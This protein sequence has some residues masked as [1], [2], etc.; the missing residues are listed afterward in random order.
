MS[1]VL[2]PVSKA[3]SQFIPSALSV[4]KDCDREL[5]SI[6][7]GYFVFTLM[8]SLFCKLRCP[9]CY[10]SL[11]QRQDRTI[12][13]VADLQTTCEKVDAY[14]DQQ[15][16]AQ[17]TIVC[18]WYGG[19]P[20]SM[21]QDYFTNAAEAINGVF[22]PGQ[23]YRV[24]HT[25]LTSLV[26]V[27]DDWFALFD[28]Y[29]KG[30]VQSSYD[31][32]MRGEGYMK[33]WDQRARAAVASGLRLSTISVVNRELLNQGPEATLDYLA[34]IGVAETSWLPFMWNEQNASGAYADYAPSMHE[35][36]DF[37]VGL[38][39]HW[40]NQRRRG[41]A[42]PEIG[43]LRFILHQSESPLLA[44]IAGQ[45]LFLLPNGDFVLP[46]Y[47]NGWQEFMRVFG[48]IL[49]QDFASILTS[50][51]RRRYLRRQVFRNGNAECLSCDHTDKC[52]MEFW[53]DNRPGDVCFG[54]KAYV[55][56]IL[57]NRDAIKT[58][59]GDTPAILY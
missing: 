48:N 33:R 37:M 52:I 42:V 54:A 18:Y 19:E 59:T 10:L 5:A 17:K 50:P 35:Y 3:A 23:G 36:C 4:E 38:S 21:G 29:G 49:E 41:V 27:K 45:T 46:D 7:Q 32:N 25:V 44:N 15:Q 12:M 58:I 2:D 28:H 16:I 34:D 57:E 11:E 51:A 31:G 39:E 14:Y 9:H 24:K 26:G 43:Q 40:I 53:K 1:I 30:E 13:S 47:H 22:N 8:P 55:E 6:E 56:W 20:T